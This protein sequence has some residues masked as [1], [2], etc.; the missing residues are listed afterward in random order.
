MNQ[1]VEGTIVKSISD[2]M[3]PMRFSDPKS[4]LL[5]VS[6][7]FFSGIVLVLFN[8]VLFLLLRFQKRKI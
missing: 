4:T 8:F 7:S 2:T 3:K 1:L 5:N 6:K